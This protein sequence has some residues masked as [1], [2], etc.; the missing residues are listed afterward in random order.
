[1]TT[2]HPTTPELHAF[3]RGELD[4]PRFE[5]V[6]VHLE[7]CEACGKVL[8]ETGV[9]PSFSG[10]ETETIVSSQVSEDAGSIVGPYKLL[11]KLG[12]GGMGVVYMAEQ[13]KPVRRIVALK[14][15]KPGMDSK[16]VIARFEA[17]RQA[18]A[19]MDHHNIAKVLDAGTTDTGRP[20]F[21]MELVK[22]VPI[23]EYC[24]RNKLTPR[25]RLQ[26]FIPVCQAIQHAHQKGVIHRDI[27]PS[28][29]LVTLYD[30]QPVPKVI[31]FGI[32]K[33]TQQKLTERTMFTGIGQILGTLEYMSPEQAEMNQLD[34]DTR[35]DVY[36]LGVMLYEL[37]TG[38]TPITK[39]KLR[40]VGLEEMLRT[41]RETEPP[42]PSTRLSDSGEALPSIS[43]VRKTAPTK[44][45][46][47]VRGD[48]DW[49]VMKA[50]EKDRTRRYETANGLAMDVQRFL[51]D[52]TVE[53]CPPSPSYRFRKFARRNKTAIAT[54]VAVATV[55]VIATIVSSGLAIWALH[56]QRIATENETAAR[57]SAAAAELSR[58]NE[59][60]HRETAVANATRAQEVATFLKRMLE[61]VGPSA[62]L[63]RD[64]ALLREILATTMDRVGQDLIDQP[65]VAADLFATM[66]NVYME[67]G[68][69]A[70]AENACDRALELLKE[71]GSEAS[72][73]SAEMLNLRGELHRK[74]AE[75]T[76]AKSKFDQAL[77]IRRALLDEQSP[78][79]AESLSDLGQVY[80]EM[81]RFDDADT[82]EKQ[83]LGIRRNVFADA[84]ESVAESM[85]R[86]AYIYMAKGQAEG[87][88]T[89][90]RD[91][92]EICRKVL[93]E[94]H[95][96]F[97]ESLNDMGLILF[98]QHK[99]G[100]MVDV[101]EENL[102]IVQSLYEPDHPEQST[103]LN[104]LA[105]AYHDQ[106][107][108]E[109]SAEMY[110]KVIA[111]ERRYARDR[112]PTFAVGLSNYAGLLID[113]NDLEKAEQIAR[114]SLAIHLDQP[115]MHY[116]FSGAT[117]TLARILFKQER[118]PEA[119]E[120]FRDLYQQIGRERGIVDNLCAALRFQGPDRY[121]EV[122]QIW[123]E[124]VEEQRKRGD[125]S[126]RL[127]L[128]LNDL[129]I[130]LGKMGRTA[131]QEAAQRESLANFRAVHG[132]VQRDVATLSLNLGSTL[133]TQG[134]FK[135]AEQLS[136]EGL[137]IRQKLYA[138]DHPSILDG[139][140]RLGALLAHQWDLDGSERALRDALAMARRLYP[141]A[142][143]VGNLV[144][145]LPEVL[146][147]QKKHEEAKTL[148]EEIIGSLKKTSSIDD[149]KVQ[150]QLDGLVAVLRWQAL[151]NE[152]L[153][154]LEFAEAARRQIVDW[155]R[156][157]TSEDSKEYGWALHKLGE[158]L[159]RQNKS[160]SA[161]SALQES[162]NVLK[163]ESPEHRSTVCRAGAVRC[164][165]C[166]VKSPS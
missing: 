46:K 48:L 166:Q 131:K 21:A 94:N 139:L 45:S 62:A 71:I 142:P 85:S 31:D 47:L 97:Q 37:L 111:L 28:N 66:A 50:L 15:I 129:A 108:F 17:E 19:M 159:L 16:Q 40:T 112:T 68:E 20:Y 119:E 102:A 22:G 72:L 39:E 52:E 44:L 33:A 7:M 53:A 127:A 104:N 82:L 146:V 14:I 2:A 100:E 1:M 141:D 74:R 4:D 130:A 93:G 120:L 109:K 122:E 5:E 157:I 75:Y 23:T 162:V 98:R 149:P 88:E 38:S 29:V 54:G 41:I 36:S 107:A 137:R 6:A 65:D 95:P 83:A 80:Y 30:G 144:N 3:A 10:Q 105:T 118:Y 81:E 34:V 69:Q 90:A 11:Q 58:K 135:E 78:A 150:S 56:A 59:Q 164:C 92:L 57:Q 63:G 165:A 101:F 24:D 18:L 143:F 106:R 113:L 64:T 96:L 145:D 156:D 161:A 77:T 124:Y 151:E 67:L 114:E 152:R 123:R 84:H 42:K 89:L 91:A 26:M 116:Q 133:S 13:E 110:A 12:E 138:G 51:A 70:S 126:H 27:K 25:E 160:E 73:S 87:A 79:V 134:K 99:V 8:A 35:T 49:I 128:A 147:L 60:V 61:S 117:N 154:K 115:E 158:N 136:R 103:A 153:G 148:H 163:K 125:P 55:L 132:G 121:D 86:L 43:A 32:A 76:L 155:T 9:F 140:S